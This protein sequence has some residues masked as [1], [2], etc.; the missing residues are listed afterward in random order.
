MIDVVVLLLTAIFAAAL[1]AGLTRL[2]GNPD[3][4][5]TDYIALIVVLALTLIAGYISWRR[6]AFYAAHHSRGTSAGEKAR[7]LALA[8]VLGV[9]LVFGVAMGIRQNLAEPSL[10]GST[11]QSMLR[12]N[13]TAAEGSPV[14]T[15]T[16][17][18]PEGRD[19]R[20]GDVARCTVR[21]Y[22]NASEVLV[23]TVLREGEEW[24]LNIDIG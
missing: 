14:R 8:G 2:A 9:A 20:E 4:L 6:S 23:V 1:C 22:G 19:F 24:S 16:I 21:T 13:L 3:E 17:R 15:D 5:S 7:N 18:C 10:S 12:S 11:M